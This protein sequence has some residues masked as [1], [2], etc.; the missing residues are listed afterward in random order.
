MAG[1]PLSF[2]AVPTDGLLTGGR[3]AIKF[4]I[5]FKEKLLQLLAQ[6]YLPKEA[7][8]AH[9]VVWYCEEDGKEYRVALPRI[10][11]RKPG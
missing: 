2:S 10:M 3:I 1:S 11:L 5:K 4:S 8:V 6:G 7:A 9:I